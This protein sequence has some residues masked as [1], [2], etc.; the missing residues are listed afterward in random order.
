MGQVMSWKFLFLLINCK[1]RLDTVS[2]YVR[3]ILSLVKRGLRRT[4]QEE[5]EPNLI[6]PVMLWCITPFGR[7]WAASRKCSV[8][9]FLKDS[10]LDRKS[11]A[12]FSLTAKQRNSEF[13][14]PQ[15]VANSDTSLIDMHMR[16]YTNL[17]M[18]EYILILA[19]TDRNLNSLGVESVWSYSPLQ[20]ILAPHT[21]W[22]HTMWISHHHFL[23]Q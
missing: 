19:I 17:H 9:L 4:W 22:E 16:V 18:H 20:L 15:H 11:H 5:G 21:G 14:W 12:P 10:F 8:Y 7:H 1:G 2:S 3:C 23:Q 6:L 13:R